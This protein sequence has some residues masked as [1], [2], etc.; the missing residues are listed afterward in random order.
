MS[1]ENKKTKELFDFDAP[2]ISL[3]KRGANKKSFFLL[4]HDGGNNMTND[5]LVELVQSLN[6]VELSEELVNEI[7]KASLQ[8][9]DMNRFRGAMKLLSSMKEFPKA[10]KKQLGEAFDMFKE[11]ELEKQEEETKVSEEPKKE[12]VEKEVETDEKPKEEEVEKEVEKE[13]DEEPK[14]EVEKEEE[15]EEE[16]P[17]ILELVQKNE[18]NEK[19]IAKMKEEKVMS[20]KMEEAKALNSLPLEAE[21]L[22]T[23]LKATEEQLDEETNKALVELLKASHSQ[24]SNDTVLLKEIGSNAT[25][26]S[27]DSYTKIYKKAEKIAKEEEIT[28]EK[29]ISKVMEQEPK[30]YEEYEKEK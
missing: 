3:V 25:P 13:E 11:C 7:Q 26:D 6:E 20:L 1:P 15:A 22:A 18:E 16:D 2:F 17:R 8:E 23:F 14:K 12:E 24:M 29:A 19:L 21:K 30:L 28:I 5:K 4:K 9:E 27:N 10:M